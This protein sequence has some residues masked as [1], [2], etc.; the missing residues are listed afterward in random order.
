MTVEGPPDQDI[1]RFMDVSDPNTVAPPQL[2]LQGYTFRYHVGDNPK[3]ARAVRLLVA[4]PR[5]PAPR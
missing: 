5:P 4:P 3:P 2:S 1:R